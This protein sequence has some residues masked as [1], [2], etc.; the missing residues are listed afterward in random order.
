MVSST[1]RLQHGGMLE[2]RYRRLGHPKDEKKI[3][4]VVQSGGNGYTFT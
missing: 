3:W 1:A 2:A 4:T